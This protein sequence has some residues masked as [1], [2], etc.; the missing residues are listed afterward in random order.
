MLYQ[1]K[2]YRTLTGKVPFDDWMDKLS[3]KKALVAIEVRLDRLTL[4]NFG[5][6]KS[7]GDGV[8]E[9][10]IDLGPGYRVY[11]SKVGGTIVLLLCA[12]DKG[13]QQKDITKAKKYLEDYRIREGKN[14]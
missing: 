4:G 10:K 8:H 14:D 6:C 5:Q 2:I 12:G 7:V 3:D 1:I 9:L 13:S 11:L